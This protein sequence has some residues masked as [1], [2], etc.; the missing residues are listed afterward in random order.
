MFIMYLMLFIMPSSHD[1]RQ[2]FHQTG[3]IRLL[4]FLACPDGL[5]G[6]DFSEY[7]WQQSD[8]N[9]RS[10]QDLYLASYTLLSV[11]QEE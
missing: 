11:V 10:F 7:T 8:P 5:S 9:T 1:S 6:K 3:Y 4:G 2:V